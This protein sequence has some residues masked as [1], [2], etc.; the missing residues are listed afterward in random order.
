MPD[1]KLLTVMAH[2]DDETF[3]LG[4]TLALYAMRGV[5]VHL[6]CATNGEAGTVDPRFL[7]GYSEIAELRQAELRCAADKLGLSGLHLLGYRDSGMV[8]TA[9]NQHPDALAQAD[10]EQVVGQI[11][12]QLRRVRPQVV[13]THDPAGGYGHPD[14]IAVH[15]TTV[16][17]F[18]AA[19]DP[20]RYPER[21]QPFA[22]Q[23]LYYS[24]ISMRY[25]NGLIRIA[26]LLGKDP[27]RWGRNQDI[28]LTEI[29]A[30]QHP[31]NAKI[32][33][34]KVADRKREATAC[35]ASQLDMGSSSR[36]LFGML[37]RLLRRGNV[38]SFT[39]AHPPVTNGRTEEDLFAG[40]A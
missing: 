33:F 8:G 17:A 35:H 4:G 37:A 1:L 12:E 39:R 6:V 25:M 36:G 38:E 21:G 20:A 18:R 26:R 30:N 13:I 32:N 34:R 23:K 14:H 24:T 31:I 27:T 9:E 29:A 16:E 7:E 22:P 28:D 19:G 3:A 10:S 40:V 5:E 11:V 2:P 15:K